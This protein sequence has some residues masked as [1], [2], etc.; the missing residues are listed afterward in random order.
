MRSAKHLICFIFLIIPGI[1]TAASMIQSRSNNELST[2]YIDGN[3]ARI[4]TS[5]NDGFLVMDVANKS[6]KM[7]IHEFQAILDMSD[8]FSRSPAPVTTAEGDFIDTYAEPKGLGPKISGYETEEYEIFANDK[9]CGSAFVSVRAIQET[10]MRKFTGVLQ[11][12]ESHIQQ[13]MSRFSAPSQQSLCD[14]ANNKLTD[15]IQDIGFPLK[16]IDQYKQ[17]THEITSINTRATLPANAFV[18][19]AHYKLTTPS[20]MMKNA[21]KQI[22][23]AAPFM[24]EMMKSISPEDREMMLRKLQQLQR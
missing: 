5:G 20:E 9:Y 24:L 23:N 3:K 17:L 15:K 12:L 14:S 21:T 7:V 19:P 2:I 6:L 22:K 11:N 18:I 8:I 16:S 1:S 13:K 4:E 10:G